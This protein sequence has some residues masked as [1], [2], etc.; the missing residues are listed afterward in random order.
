MKVLIWAFVCTVS[1]ITFFAITASDDTYKFSPHDQWKSDWIR[2]A[3]M[4]AEALEERDKKRRHEDT[5]EF[6]RHIKQWNEGRK[7]R[8]RQIAVWQAELREEER[9]VAK[10]D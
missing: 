9:E 1:I 7:A 8:L 4:E 2:D 6:E 10:Q 3:N 5:L